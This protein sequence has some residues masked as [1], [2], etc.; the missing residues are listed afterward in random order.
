MKEKK[1]FSNTK[2]AVIFFIFLGFIVGI[3]LIFKVIL[4]VRQGQFDSSRRFTLAISNSKNL[5]V[6]SLSPAKKS[7]TV[8]KLDKNVPSVKA[9]QLLAIPIDGT[10]AA[11]SLDLNQKI[12]SLFFKTVLNYKSLQTNLTIIDLLKLAFFTSSI[13]ERDIAAENISYDLSS[14]DV[15]KIIGRLAADELIEKDNQTIQIIDGTDI[16]GF[17]NRLARLVTN[18]GGDVIIVATSDSPKKKS[19]VS[20]MNKKN[21]TAERLSKVL[22]FEIAKSEESGVADITITIGEDKVNSSPF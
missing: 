1:T 9:G 3:S 19:T 5:E 6:I 20:Y 2:I 14:A 10:I 4:V 21:Y 12:N 15:D 16:V 11:N 17:G 22:G 7:I 8:F 13:P 18:M